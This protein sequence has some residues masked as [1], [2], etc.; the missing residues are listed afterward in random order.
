VTVGVG[1]I[2]GTVVGVRVGVDVIDGT[3]VMVG[4]RLGVT[5]AG[6]SEGVKLHQVPP[7]AEA[8]PLEFTAWTCQ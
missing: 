2:E 8:V 7:S 4:V 5:V 6:V 3:A 1:V